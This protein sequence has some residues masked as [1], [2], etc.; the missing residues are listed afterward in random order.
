[1]GH[2]LIDCW[3]V[4]DI[5]VDIVGGT[6]LDSMDLGGMYLGVLFHLLFLSPL[7]ISCHKVITLRLLQPCLN[8]QL[9]RRS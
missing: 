8:G 7:L 1:M 9:C 5:V 6:L 3:K 2:H 4:I